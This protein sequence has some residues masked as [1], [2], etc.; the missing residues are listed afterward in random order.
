MA[1]K[2]M[3]RKGDTKKNFEKTSIRL[4]SKSGLLP[5]VPTKPKI[6]TF[7]KCCKDSPL[8]TV[9]S[10]GC[11]MGMRIGSALRLKWSDIDLNVGKMMIL[12]DKNVKRFK[13]QYG[14]DRCLDIPSFYLPI[15]KM[16][17]NIN[18]G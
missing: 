8:L 16:W 7:V 15:L 17:K 2:G 9:Y 11:F 12:D 5:H 3:N 18:R 1:K 6:L 10:L 14:K 13:S 4:N